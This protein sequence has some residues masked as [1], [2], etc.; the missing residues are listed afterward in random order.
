M[1]VEKF[2]FRNFK[3]I[4]STDVEIGAGSPGKV[5]TLIGLN[6]SGKTTILEA[7]SNFFMGDP[8]TKS[9]VETVQSREPVDALVP[10]SKKGI[11]NGNIEIAATVSLDD[12]DIDAVCRGIKYLNYI[13]DRDTFA[14]KFEIRL[15][16]IFR[17]GDLH[18][19]RTTWGLRFKGKKRNGSVIRDFD[20]SGDTRDGWLAALRVL[21]ER[22]P[23]IVYF[24]TFLFTFPDRIYLREPASWEENSEQA[25]INRYY[26]RVLQDV[27]DSI[28]EGD[29]ENRISIDSQ[30]VKRLENVKEPT[31]NPFAFWAYFVSQKEHDKVR[32]VLNRIAERMGQVVFTAW[33]KIFDKPT[34][35]SRVQVDFGVDPEN[36]NAPWVQLSIFDGKSTYSLSERSLGFRWFFSFLLFTQFR[37]S[38]SDDLGSIF[39][40]DEPASNLHALA[41]MRLMEGFDGIVDDRNFIV[42][43]THS[44]YLINPMWLEKAYIVRN[45]AIDYDADLDVGSAS[46]PETDIEAIGYRDFV[47]RYPSRISY[48]QPALDALRFNLGPMVFGKQAVIVEGK[49]D[50][51]PLEYFRR[52]FG[53]SEEYSIFPI[54][55]AGDAA[56]VISLLR[57]WGVNYLILLDDD[58]AGNSARRKYENDLAVPPD[59]VVQLSEVSERLKGKAFEAIYNKLVDS[60]AGAYTEKA[61]PNKRAYYDLFLDLIS[62]ADYE[63]KFGSTDQMAGKIL[64][65]IEVRFEKISQDPSGL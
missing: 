1:K 34:T 6:E 33:N 42:Y 63:T 2:S 44:H 5:I 64:T 8:E 36:E 43:S 45:L 47:N 37:K 57:G 15:K 9:L 29:P 40:F 55:G 23:K 48:F 49:F 25:I 53:K 7:I 56:P 21:K 18:D 51:H 52:K 14:R 27:A 11:F 26:R 32:S 38:R 10:K 60:K 41:Q 59:R 16:F 50:F 54:N 62:K 22:A 30:V 3:G 13:A 19:E 61:K 58:G 35:G 28:S 4:K 12:A 17:D 20:G 31:G 65:E 46:E 39:L 24:P